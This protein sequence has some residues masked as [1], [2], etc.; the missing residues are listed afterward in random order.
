MSDSDSDVS[1]SNSH[2]EAVPEPAPESPEKPGYAADIQEFFK[3]LGISETQEAE[4]SKLITELTQPTDTIIKTEQG[5]IEKASVNQLILN[6]T[7]NPATTPAFPNTFFASLKF[8]TTPNYVAAALINLFL[9]APPE[10]TDIRVNITDVLERWSTAY[11]EQTTPEMREPLNRLVKLA[12]RDHLCPSRLEKLRQ[13]ASGLVKQRQIS[14][15]RAP[16]MILPKGSP[17]SW[18][19]TMIPEEELAR[20]ITIH[21]SKL[22]QEIKIDDLARPDIGFGKAV[23]DLKEH[24]IT[25]SNYVTL[26][27]IM[28]DKAKKRAEQYLKWVAVAYRLLQSSNFSGM[29]GIYSGLVHPAITRLE[30]TMKLVEKKLKKE[31]KVR[32]MTDTVAQV[33]SPENDYM[34][35]RGMLQQAPPSCIPWMELFVKD[36]SGVLSDGEIYVDGLVNFAKCRKI[37]AL[38]N[39]VKNCQTPRSRCAFSPHERIQE[40]ISNLPKVTEPS[41][42]MMLSTNKESDKKKKK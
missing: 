4:L 8:F 28:P 3:L 21:H 40:L 30:K 37:A 9:S 18:T 23:S 15:F 36:L 32:E 39:V 5:E 41:Q 12:E 6:L 16:S 14:L 13:V 33:Y 11:E 17:L 20:Q 7:N 34:R 19:V 26:S 38:V 1:D 10:N 35:Y 31:E 24:T 25:L 29:F 27:I 22:F 2:S 42:M